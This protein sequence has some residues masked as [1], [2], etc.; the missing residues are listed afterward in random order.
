[1]STVLPWIVRSPR[2]SVM[3]PPA[4]STIGTIAQRSQGERRLSMAMSARPDATS[5]YP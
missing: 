2:Q 3:R 1:M 5:P 4:S